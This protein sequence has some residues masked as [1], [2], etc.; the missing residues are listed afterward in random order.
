MR[1]RPDV[2]AAEASL[3]AANAQLGVAIA[4]RLP[5]ITLSGNA[6]STAYAVSHLFAPGTNFWMIAGNALQP[7][8]D[9]GTLRYRQRGG[10]GGL[11]QS[12][13]QY[14]G[15][16][17]DGL[18]ERRRHA[19][20]SAG[21]CPRPQC[22]DGGGALGIAQHRPRSQPDRAGP[23]QP[24]DPAQ[25]AAGLPAD[26]A[27]AR[28]GGGGAPRRHGRPVP[29]AGRRLVEQMGSHDGTCR[30]GSHELACYSSRVDRHAAP[31]A[32]HR[33]AGVAAWLCG[34]GA[35]AR[36]PAAD[37]CR[38]CLRAAHQPAS[39]KGNT[40]RITA[41]QMHQLEVVKVEA[42]VFRAEKQAIGQIAF[43]EDAS[44]VVLTPFSGRVTRLIAKIGDEVKRGDPLF[45]IDSPEVVQAQTDLIAAVQGRDKSKSQ[46]ALAKRTFDRQ[47]GL[48]AVKAT[49]QRELEQANTDHTAA[50]TDVRTAEGVSTPPA[51]ACACSAAATSRWRAWKGNG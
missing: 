14:R 43:N 6:G 18:P 9:G 28:A 30:L 17:L 12:V 45:E 1:Q 23:G 31:R 47:S 42:T 35:A 19:A 16:V 2:R 46:L 10:R 44:T 49:S 48:F 51:I 5:Q 13:A 26:I 40:V 34:I 37:H 4:N 3:H 8:F 24:A 38:S 25:C 11:V 15:T 27:G 22:G 7:I 39:Q 33:R 29:G 50:E 41:D 20:G 32:A 36:R 21:R